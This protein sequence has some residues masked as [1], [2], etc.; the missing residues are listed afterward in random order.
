M[1]AFGRVMEVGADALLLVVKAFSTDNERYSNLREMV[2]TAATDMVLIPDHALQRN[3]QVI[4]AYIT[5]IETC[6]L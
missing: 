6:T 4:C 2:E 1:I 3:V 5:N